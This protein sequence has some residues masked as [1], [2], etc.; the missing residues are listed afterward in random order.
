MKKYIII[1]AVGRDRPGFVNKITHAITE[2]G[3]NI[4]L[5]RSTR[6]AL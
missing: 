3:G 2:L 1:S 4:D 6:M 5:Q